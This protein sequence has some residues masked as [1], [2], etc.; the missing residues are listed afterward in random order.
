MSRYVYRTDFAIDLLGRA[1]AL[2][3]TDLFLTRSDL[4]RMAFQRMYALLDMYVQEE[5]DYGIDAV[6]ID[7]FDALLSEWEEILFAEG[8]LPNIYEWEVVA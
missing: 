6:I 8:L 4:D 2:S 3:T 5:D 7:D 1:D